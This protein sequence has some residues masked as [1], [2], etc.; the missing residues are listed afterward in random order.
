M[1]ETDNGV[2]ITVDDKNGAT[3]AFI[4]NGEKG[5]Q[6]I[7]GKT[8]EKGDKG[9]KGEDGTGVTI[10]GSFNTKEELK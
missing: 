4:K 2:I 9:D 8:G 6:G 3:T 7:Q 10:L 1:T 5:E